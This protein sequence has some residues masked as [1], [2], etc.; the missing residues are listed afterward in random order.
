M[1]VSRRFRP[2]SFIDASARQRYIE[3]LD[4]AFAAFA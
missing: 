2:A 4:A 3:R 1:A